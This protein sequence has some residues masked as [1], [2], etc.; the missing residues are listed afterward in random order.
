MTM[1]ETYRTRYPEEKIC[2]KLHVDSPDNELGIEFTNITDYTNTK[3]PRTARNTFGI[4]IDSISL[5][6][7]CVTMHWKN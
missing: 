1:D 3:G 7:F 4:M 6:V 5:C 2:F